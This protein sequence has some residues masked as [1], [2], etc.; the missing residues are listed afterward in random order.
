M[1]SAN[2]KGATRL[3]HKKK[4]KHKNAAAQALGHRG[5]LKGGP[6]RAAVL[7]KEERSK[8]ASQGGVARHK[9]N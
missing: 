3:T 9:G 8:I 2:R 1:S 5:G 7:S 6:A 4:V